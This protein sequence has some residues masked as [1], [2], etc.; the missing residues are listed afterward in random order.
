MYAIHKREHVSLETVHTNYLYKDIV[1]YSMCLAFPGIILSIE[2]DYAKVDFGAG[3]VRDDINIAEVRG[4][5]VGDYVLVHAGYAIQVL[6]LEEAYNAIRYWE[7]NLVW[8]CERCSIAYEC[9]L[10]SIATARKGISL[11]GDG[12]R[13][14]ES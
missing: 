6:D 5:N 9:P 10:G 3:V 8:K 2:G 4:V 11:G 14:H 13:G 1:T 7:E 12:K